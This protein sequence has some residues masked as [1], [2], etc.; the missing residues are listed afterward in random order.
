MT[1][2]NHCSKSP[3][4]PDKIR[5]L[6]FSDTKFPLCFF[7]RCAEIKIEFPFLCYSTSGQSIV[8][9]CSL[10]LHPQFSSNFNHA[11]GLQQTSSRL[12]MAQQHTLH[13][14]YHW[15]RS[16]HR[17]LPLRH[18][19]PHPAFHPARPGFR[20]SRQDPNL[21]IRPPS[22]FRRSFHALLFTNRHNSG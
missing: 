16:L 17:S 18:R 8:G 3:E 15:Y 21:H 10:P 11:H 9:C 6:F 5:S 20:P 12:K 2:F 14:Y 4:V 19:R 7:L 13:N 1:P 22:L